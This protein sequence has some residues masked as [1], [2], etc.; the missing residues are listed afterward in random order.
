M[1][2]AQAKPKLVLTLEKRMGDIRIPFEREIILTNQVTEAVNNIRRAFR[3]AE[4]TLSKN[5]NLSVNVFLLKVNREK[6]RLFG[7]VPKYSIN[8]QV[9][10]EGDTESVAEFLKQW[11]RIWIWWYKGYE[12]V[13]PI[14]YFI[15]TAKECG[16]PGDW[17]KLKGYIESVEELTR[18]S[19][20]SDA[21]ELLQLL[22]KKNSP[23]EELRSG[24]PCPL[25]R[26]ICPTIIKCDSSLFFVAM[27]IKPEYNDILQKIDA[28]LEENGLRTWV[29]QKEV[30]MRHILCKICEKIQTCENGIFEITELKPNVM[31]ELGLAYG[32][33]KSIVLLTKSA[34]KVPSDLKG[35]E[36]IEYRNLEELEK[37]LRQ[38]LLN[39]GCI[40]K[41]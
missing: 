3:F 36:V 2:K 34:S 1:A 20:K 33:G 11:A 21:Y 27:P 39:K 14:E 25:T 26:K 31:L 4:E 37:K 6:R 22:R 8:I 19:L 35:L 32:L 10:V 9:K 7:K 28:V 29:A 5:I 13:D 12:K 18:E 41:N 30:H 40:P 17:W 24:L 38:Y 15:K 16:T 23:I